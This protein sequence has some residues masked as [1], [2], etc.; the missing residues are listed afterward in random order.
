MAKHE[1]SEKKPKKRS[2]A[3]IVLLIILLILAGAAGFLYYSIVKAP[4][5]L[6][7]P[8]KMASSA[9]M[10]P[11]ERFRFSAADGTVQMKVNAVDIWN[12]VLTYAG[13]DFLDL[14]NQKL[15]DYPLTVSGCGFQV[16]ETGPWLNLELFYQD[17]RVTA[18]VPF[19]LEASGQH[20]RLK[21]TGV[22]VGVI[23][24]PVE[25]LLSSV[26]VE[27][28]LPLPVISDITEVAYEPGAIVLTGSMQEDLG[29]LISPDRALY[30]VAVFDESVQTMAAAMETEAGYKALLA[31][32]EQDPGGIVDVYRMLFAMA[33]PEITQTYLDG[34]MNLTQWVL[35]GIE[36]DALDAVR[37][38]EVS[39]EEA[40]YAILVRFFTS[41]VSD[42]NGKVFSLSDGEFLKKL[43][44]FHPSNYGTGN[45]DALYQVLDP[46]EF[47]LVLVDAENGY[48][49]KTPSFDKI[50]DGAQQFTQP[51]DYSRTY[52]LGFVFRGVGGAPFLLYEA[53]AR[54]DGDSERSLNLQ[55]LSEEEV[56]ALKVPGKF[57]V[58]TG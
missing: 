23:P 53:E 39:E 56:S 52:I 11:E 18:K 2:R 51:V 55:I 26:A 16:D 28:D 31:R 35:P 34:H 8:Q 12:L 57:G 20:F 19:T 38:E 46:D 24:L 54:T 5:A 42:Y 25:E 13:A 1:T 48:T 27:G 30:R 21:P 17:I 22:K 29:S 15:T 44:P 58:W 7:D 36:Y 4:I 32:L 9:P 6:D 33:G 14:V 41:V 47:F 3:G 37:A 45:Y 43:K 50:A 49:A 10:T 40:L